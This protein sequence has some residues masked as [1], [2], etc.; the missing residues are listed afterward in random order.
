[1][2]KPP[3]EDQGEEDEEDEIEGSMSVYKNLLA[4]KKKERQQLPINMLFTRK[5]TPAPT[6]SVEKDATA[7]QR[8]DEEAWSEEL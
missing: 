1:M 6:P 4:Q 2:A 3:S 7:E 8:Q 5:K